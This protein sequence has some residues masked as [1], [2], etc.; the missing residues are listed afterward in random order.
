MNE[1]PFIWDPEGRPSWLRVL[2]GLPLLAYRCVRW[3]PL[4]GGWLGAHLRRPRFDRRAFPPGQPIDV[5][6]LVADHYEPARR[7]GDEAAVESVRSW[8]AQYEVLAGEH[9]DADG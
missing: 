6:V 8:C 2:A 4:R 9:R 5:M 3:R 1:Y 7:H